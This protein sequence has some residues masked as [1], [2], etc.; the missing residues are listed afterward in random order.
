MSVRKR[1]EHWHVDFQINGVRGDRRTC[2][3]RRAFA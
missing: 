1:G 2:G 3:P